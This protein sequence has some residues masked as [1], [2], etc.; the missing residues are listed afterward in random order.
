MHR[1]AR[2]AF[3]PAV[4]RTLTRVNHAP[5]SRASPSPMATLSVG[6]GRARGMPSWPLVRRV[7]VRT[8]CFKGAPKES[9]G[10]GGG[11]GWLGGGGGFGSGSGSGGDGGDGGRNPLRRLLALY[12]EAVSRRPVVTKSLTTMVLGGCGDLL[13]QRIAAHQR[14]EPLRVDV[15]R[16]RAVAL[17]GLLFMGPMLHTWYGA[18]DRIYFG[19]GAAWRKMLTDQLLFST[20]FNAAFLVGVAALQGTPVGDA[21]AALRS[22]LWPSM[23]ANWTLWPAAQMINFTLVPKPFQM[24]YVNCVGIVWN[25]ILSYIAHAQPAKHQQRARARD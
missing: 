5:V 8:L 10:N 22:T 1:A 19:A 17:W 13:A 15:V 7:R 20:P 6:A 3:A 18:L 23:K 4:A 25:S 9:G 11:R 24:V 21:V 12:V 2:I 14:G 16:L